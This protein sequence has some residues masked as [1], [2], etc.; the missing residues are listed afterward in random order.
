[1]KT[2]Y[3]NHA[4]SN[5]TISVSMP[6]EPRGSYRGSNEFICKL[7][8][9]FFGFDCID[10]DSLIIDIRKRIFLKNGVIRL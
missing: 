2:G 9:C 8:R 10:L 4:M 3:D 5:S 7:I 1:M 6:Q